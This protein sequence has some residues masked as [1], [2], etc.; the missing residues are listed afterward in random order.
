MSGDPLGLDDRSVLVEVA[1]VDGVSLEVEHGE[2]EGVPRLPVLRPPVPQLPA[3][4]W[5]I[6]VA[7]RPGHVLR[8]AAVA[9][10]AAEGDA[11]VRLVEDAAVLVPP[12]PGRHLAALAHGLR[13]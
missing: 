3:D 13:L 9:E 5:L 1:D 11:P 10:A 7:R 8:N 2:A 6:R 12:E 4:R